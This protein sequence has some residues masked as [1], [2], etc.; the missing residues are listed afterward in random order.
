[1]SALRVLH[2][3]N[4]LTK[5]QGEEEITD[6]M[7]VE[8][9]DFAGM[10]R[11]GMTSAER[12]EQLRYETDDDGNVILEDLGDEEPFKRPRPTYQLRKFACDPEGYVQLNHSAGMFWTQDDLIR[13]ILKIEIENEYVIKSKKSKP[14]KAGTSSIKETDT[15]PAGRRVLTRKTKAAGKAGGKKTAGKGPK[16]GGKSASR[17]GRPPA[18]RGPTKAAKGDDGPSGL[19][20]PAIDLEAFGEDLQVKVGEAIAAAT[21]PLVETI[22]ELQ[23]QVAANLDAVT[24][25][26]DLLAQ[27]AGT[28]Q[29]EDDE[30]ELQPIEPMFEHPNKILGHLDEEGDDD[31]SE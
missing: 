12:N 19:P 10:L 6:E 20:P 7:S 4:I 15:M 22:Q 9:P 23:Q 11:E 14:A 31:P 5:H 13:H 18:K 25:L 17:V 28:M 1:M 26:H 3:M 29:Y 2:K 27:T 30:G 24:V 16:A 8:I 21:E